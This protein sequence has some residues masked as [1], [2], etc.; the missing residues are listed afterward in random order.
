MAIST[1]ATYLRVFVDE[2]ERLVPHLVGEQKWEWVDKQ[3][4]IIMRLNKPPENQS[5]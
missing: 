1:L 2:K 4:I 3:V 5:Q